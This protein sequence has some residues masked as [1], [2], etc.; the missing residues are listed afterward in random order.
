VVVSDRLTKKITWAGLTITPAA[1]YQ[2]A[3]G[4]VSSLDSSRRAHELASK[5]KRSSASQPVARIQTDTTIRLQKGALKRAN[6][7]QSFAEYDP[8]LASSD[9]YVHTPA[10]N[11]AQDQE[12]GK[13][14][15]VGRRGMG[16]TAIRLYCGDNL[17]HTR[18]IVPEIFSP[19]AT[20]SES[21]LLENTKARPFQSLKSAFRRSLQVELLSLYAQ[22]HPALTE[23]PRRLADEIEQYGSI[24]FDVR[25]LR[26]IDRVLAP[27]ESGD[28]ESWLRENKASREI[29]DLMKVM[30]TS[31]TTYTVL[32]DSIDDYWEGSEGGLNYLT[33]F[34]HACQEITAQIP[35]ARTL[36]FL[37]ENIFERV[38]A[39]DSESSRLET[40]VVGMEWTESHL[41][42]LVER[43]LN[44]NLTTKVGLGGQTIAAFFASPASAWGEI[45]DYCQRR[46]RDVL[47][48]VNNA[49]EAAQAAGHDQILDVDVAQARRRFSDN[50]LQDLG[51]EYSENYAQ[52]SLVLQRFY[53]LGNR[54]TFSGMASVLQKLLADPEVSKLCGRWIFDNSSP[55]LFV[56]LL[57][58]IGFAG[59]V[60]GNN[61]PKFRSLGPQ[62]TSPPP[63]TTST[64]IVIHKCYWDALDLQDVLI[65]ELTEEQSFGRIGVLEDLPGGL[66]P[67]DYHE[68][69][70]LCLEMLDEMPHGNPGASDFEDIVGSVIKLCFFRALGNVAPKVRTSDGRAIRDWIASN[71]ASDGFWEQIR[72]RYGASQ[73]VFEC[74][75]YSQ[76]KASDFHQVGSYMGTAGGKFVVLVFR[77]E[78]N[79]SYYDHIRGIH[80]AHR[81]MVLLITEKDLR[82]FLRQAANGK[83]KEDHIQDR[84]DNLV[85]SIS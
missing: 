78:L 59:L 71:R 17:S 57:Y 56:R 25:S 60:L 55:E 6:I 32:I 46:P 76:L 29:A 15:F 7:G 38:R 26:F 11:A 52:L 80:A 48:Y 49:V 14:F 16:K 27:L 85:R 73:V 22:T 75:N 64:D 79:S 5:R 65:R 33:A 83:V 8:A 24:D 82:V 43:R 81:G 50:R 9:V 34:M 3:R 12:S 19:S 20:I 2:V 1:L 54:F 31:R 4:L 42:E 41:L 10:L 18:I 69:I 47:I 35:W 53:G 28:E 44:R 74:K 61:A 45:L 63:V 72:N 37:R 36:L 51:D 66:S 67:V 58:N 21:K 40:A 23:L 84:Y 70:N 30:T 62:D 77:G 68:E 13:V 39:R